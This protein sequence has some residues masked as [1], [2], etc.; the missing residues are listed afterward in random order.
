MISAAIWLGMA[1]H[2]SAICTSSAAGE[3]HHW[4]SGEHKIVPVVERLQAEMLKRLTVRQLRPITQSMAKA[5]SEDSQLPISKHYYLAKVG[6]VGRSNSQPVNPRGVS[7]GVDVDSKG[8]AYVTSFT[9]TSERGVSEL[10]V[11]LSSP[12]PLRRV[13]SQCDSAQ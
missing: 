13:V 8:V 10:A 6:F 4:L 9:L 5:A 7:L 3:G 2:A 12:T 11:V 1:A